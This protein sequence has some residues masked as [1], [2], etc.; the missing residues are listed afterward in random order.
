MRPDYNIVTVCTTHIY[1]VNDD[2]LFRVIETNI[3]FQQNIPHLLDNLTDEELKRE[4]RSSEN[5]TDA[6]SALVRA[7]K[8]IYQRNQN[9]QE[10]LQGKYQML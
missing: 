7:C 3:M 8:C 4:A 9:S 1:T 2:Y 6:I 10:L 5:K